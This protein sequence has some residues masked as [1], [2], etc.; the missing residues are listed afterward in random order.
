MLCFVIR[1]VSYQLLLPCLLIVID[2]R[3]FWGIRGINRLS[4]W[5]CRWNA[6]SSLYPLDVRVV[7]YLVNRKLRP[8]RRRCKYLWLLNGLYPRYRITLHHGRITEVRHSFDFLQID[9]LRLPT[10]TLRLHLYPLYIWDVRSRGNGFYGGSIENLLGRDLLKF[11][12]YTRGLQ[13]RDRCRLLMFLRC[14]CIGPNGGLS[15]SLLAVLG[16]CSCLQ[17]IDMCDT[18][19]WRG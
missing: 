5:G 6:A 8:L 14:Y 7:N 17:R 15:F 2:L 19:A 9:R 1:M 16:T 12:M 10:D 4:F 11:C 18:T 13:A 3:H